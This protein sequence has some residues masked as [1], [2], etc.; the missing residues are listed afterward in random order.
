MIFNCLD[1]KTPVKG[2]HFIE[3]SAGTGKTFAIE[4]IFIRLLLEEDL[5]FEKILVVTFTN[6]ATK[7][8]RSRIR[9]SLAEAL[10]QL[11]GNPGDRDYLAPYEKDEDTREWAKNK[12]REALLF[13]DSVAIFTIHSFCY[14]QLQE[15]ACDVLLDLKEDIP[16]NPAKIRQSSFYDYLRYDLSSEDFFPSQISAIFSQTYEVKRLLRRIGRGISHKEDKEPDLYEEIESIIKEKTGF[17]R[18]WLLEDF[19]TLFPLYKKIP[20]VEKEELLEQLEMIMAIFE[21]QK[22][23][24]L[25]TR[26]LEKKLSFFHYFDPHNRKK[27][28]KASKEVH[29]PSFLSFLH[30]A[31]YPLLTTLMNPEYIQ[32]KLSMKIENKMAREDVFSMGMRPDEILTKMLSSLE[33]QPFLKGI[34]N[35][36]EAVIVDEFQD[37]DPIQWNILRKLFV[38]SPVIRAF[39][40][41]GDP[42]QSIYGFRKADIYTYLDALSTVGSSFVRVLDTNYRSHPN[43]LAGLNAFFSPPIA[44]DWLYLPKKNKFLSF[45]PVKPGKTVLPDEKTVP[46]LIFC[47]GEDRSKLNASWPSSRYETEYLFPYMMDEIIRLHEKEHISFSSMAIL[48]KDRYQAERIGN[49]LKKNRIPYIFHGDLPV[50]DAKLRRY[51]QEIIEATLY[52]QDSSLVTKALIGPYFREEN[53]KETLEKAVHF[54]SVLRKSLFSEGFSHFVRHFFYDEF[55]GQSV[56]ERLIRHQ[57]EL[58]ADTEQILEYLMEK[59]ERESTSPYALKEMVREMESLL[60]EDDER[61]KKRFLTQ[62]ESVQIMSMHKSKGL[63][64]SVV[65]GVGLASRNSLYTIHS[66]GSPEQDAEKMRQ[67]YVVMTRAKD[68]LYVP[69]LFDE[70]KI[71]VPVG[72]GSPLELFFSS[73][74]SAME[75]ESVIEKIEILE[76]QDLARIFF[77]SKETMSTPYFSEEQ[78]EISSHRPLTAVPPSSFCYSFSTLSEEEKH[79][80]FSGSKTLDPSLLPPGPETGIIIHAIYEKIFR[81]RGEKWHQRENI[82]RHIRRVIQATS[83]E[84]HEEVLTDMVEVSLHTPLFPCSFSLSDIDISEAIVET[85]FLFLDSS[86]TFIKGFVDLVFMHKGSYYFIDWKS[87]FLGNRPDDYV[88]DRLKREMERHQYFL[89]GALYAKALQRFM[90]REHGE[91]LFG[92]AFYIF[93]RGL[94]MSPP[95]GI[96]HYFPDFKE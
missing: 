86:K 8:L 1:R 34:Q 93:V 94:T 36:F 37:T 76:K 62:K 30:S 6:L 23:D 80:S 71:T 17:R 57:R 7:E 20:S 21:G 72:M 31:L 28:Q 41:I 22:I 44:K 40:L 39:Y 12:I 53:S 51:V 26:L 89:Q 2:T 47:V 14:Y 15:Y 3:A 58:Y 66:E 81:S 70:R 79:V 29:Y 33:H 24:S 59:M 64:F 82:S 83:L 49:I 96:Y 67:L 13:F 87:N 78:K 11:L 5:S 43:L 16:Q 54:F 32:K 77:L 65:F 91:L 19:F 38:D 88:S 25:L 52:P 27:N 9:S 48:V 75:K 42:K 84:I 95:Q 55:L 92:G 10:E 56:Y 85:E 69:L 63:E 90:H 18:D 50:I 68:F 73:S 61:I 60:P 74:G 35:K 45:F 46:R 4:H